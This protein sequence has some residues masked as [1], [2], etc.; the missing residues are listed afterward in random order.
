MKLAEEHGVFNALKEVNDYDDPEKKKLSWMEQRR[1]KWR[2]N[3]K[4]K[5]EILK[6]KA[7]DKV[8]A[9]FNVVKHQLWKRS[10]ECRHFCKSAYN[11][12]GLLISHLF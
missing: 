4:R 1:E 7:R 8:K 6:L 9:T 10:D 11:L 3:E 2:A 5:K 12:P